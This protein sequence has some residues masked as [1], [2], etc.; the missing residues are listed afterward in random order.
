MYKLLVPSDVNDANDLSV[1][2]DEGPFKGFPHYATA[3]GIINYERAN[4]LADLS[5]WVI[6]QNKELFQSIFQ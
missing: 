2:V 3:G 4:V 1:D 6:L 5:G